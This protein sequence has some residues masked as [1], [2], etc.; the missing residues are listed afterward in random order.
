MKLLWRVAK[1]A[2]KYRG[3]LIIGALSTL[4]L[5]ALNLIAPRLLSQITTIVSQ[6]IT[7]EG[8]EHIFYLS[9]ALFLI[10]ALRIL[11]RFL[12]NYMSHNA[13]W[14]C[15]QD[16]R[17][18]VY[19]HMQSFSLAYFHNKQTGELMSRVVNDTAE[20]ELLYAHIMPETVTNFVT[21][22]GVL[23]I[24][25]FTNAK[26]ALL[27][28]IPVPFILLCGW[29]LAKKVQP[30][31]KKM[32]VS[33]ASLNA[34]LQDNFSGIHEIQA[35]GQQ[36][37]ESGR[38]YD[39]ASEFTKNM[40]S[41]LKLSAVF[42]PTVEFLTALGTVI[43]VGFGGYLAYRQQLTVGD[44]V[45]F[46]LYLALFYA[47][48]T[49]V[50]Q[51]LENAQQAMAGAERVLEILD[52]DTDIKDKPHAPDLPAIKGHIRFEDVSFGYIPEK[53]VLDKVSFEVEP[54]QMVALVG[55]TG[56]GKTTLIQLASRFY[57]PTMGRVTV[58]GYDL[59]DV[60][61]ESLRSQIAM[62]LQDTFLFNGTVTQNIAYARPDATMEEIVAA[63]K[64]ARIYDD[65]MQMPQGFDTHVGER[66]TKLSGGQKQRIA[67]ARAILRQAPIL[68]LDEAT[69][70]VDT[71]TE[72]QIQ[73]ALLE[74]AGTRTII[75]IAHRLSTIRRADK[76]LVF[77]NGRI[78]QSGTHEELIDT[79]GMYRDMCRVQAES[80]M[81]DFG[82]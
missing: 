59:R 6:G 76:I 39:R 43:V 28:C 19:N 35:F 14:R 15:V 13:A 41:A 70:S 2:K 10:Y 46:L 57:D 51:L 61:Q 40:L 5:T 3:L 27:T 69:A 53:Q 37:H 82:T 33:L 9:L 25:F 79:P 65:I 30:N 60:T 67:I 66:G 29:L 24:L 47:P 71:K 4:M 26:L 22:A 20:F 18:K 80:A 72:A 63:A 52:A 73:Q 42:H 54:G 56:V 17:I 75:A 8:L 34:Q 36:R 68:I 1:E 11:F 58:D 7:D 78:V 45:A 77:E 81:L 23:I 38:V 49:G 32:R 21:L 12:S 55:P 74:L 16:L 64:A 31:F 50:T 44:I 48:I 62:V